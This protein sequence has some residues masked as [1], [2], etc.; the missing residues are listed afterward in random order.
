MKLLK[1]LGRLFILLGFLGTIAITLDNWHLI[2]LPI[3][4]PQ[5]LKESIYI[6]GPF[7]LLTLLGTILFA[8]SDKK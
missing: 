5:T 7:L 4:H 6:L 2:T 3:D 1:N 8:Y